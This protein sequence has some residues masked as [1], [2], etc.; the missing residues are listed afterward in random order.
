[1]LVFVRPAQRVSP[2][3]WECLSLSFVVLLGGLGSSSPV[4]PS[5][6]DEPNPMYIAVITPK[7]KVRYGQASV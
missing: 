5:E 6:H 4:P 3:F 7:V 2:H 1:M